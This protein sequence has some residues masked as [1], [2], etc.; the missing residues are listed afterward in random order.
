MVDSDEV[1][2]GLQYSP[3]HQWLRFEAGL[4]VVGATAYGQDQL[5]DVV[6]VE[7]AKPGTRVEF[8]GNLGELESTKVLFELHSPVAGEVVEVNPAL[9]R[10]PELINEDPYG[11]GWLVSIRPG[12]ASEANKLLDAASYRELLKREAGA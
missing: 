3:E 5:G 12:D 10:N 8:M 4:A 2:E 11:K 6:Y 9:D 7:M 1:P